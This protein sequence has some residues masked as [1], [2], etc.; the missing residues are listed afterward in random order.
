MPRFPYLSVIFLMLSAVMAAVIAPNAMRI[1]PP[2]ETIE[3]DLSARF[4]A[5]VRIDGAV[6]LR[7]VPRPQIIITQV[8]FSDKRRAAARFAATM[9]QMVADL[10]IIELVQRRFRV[11]EVTL[12]DA[13]VQL[14]LSE[15]PAS[16][17]AALR[18]G[19]LP[20]VNFLN[21][22]LRIIGLD[23]LRPQVVT[24]IENL[25]ASLMAQQ[26]NGPMVLV[27]QKVIADGHAAFLQ[28]TIGPPARE[29]QIGL[30]LGLGIDEQID[31]VGF[32]SGDAENWRLNGE[33]ELLSN[34]LLMTAIEARLP[35]Q[36]TTPGRRVQLTGLVSGSA[37]GIR[38]DSMEIEALNT[39]FRSRLALNW[40]R[41]AG[42]V[43]LLDGRMSTGAV[44]LDLLRFDNADKPSG[45]LND[46]WQG[47]APDLATSFDIEATR[48]VI[49]GETGSD[50]AAQVNQNGALL[51]VE[52][53]NMNLPFRSSLLAT[54]TLDTRQDKPVFT[55][56]FSTRSSDAL[57]LLLWLGNQNNIDFSAFAEA[58]DEGTLQRASLVGDVLLNQDGLA[59]KGLAG[60]LGDDYFSADISLPDING[61]QGD[62]L[63][64]I[65]N[66]DLADWG[67]VETA[68]AGRESGIVGV[69]PQ[70]DRLLARVLSTA[71]AARKIDFDIQIGRVFA[72]AQFIGPFKAKGTVADRQVQIDKLH[73]A[74]F[75]NAEVTLNGI[76]NYDA[77][78][79]HGALSL[80]IRGDDAKWA[81]GPIVSRFGPLDFNQ[82][83]AANMQFDIQL[84]APS[85]PDWPKVIYRGTGAFGATTAALSV[86]SPSR[87]LA[88]VEAGTE[89]ALSL[90][91][92]ANGLADLFFLPPVYGASDTATM[93][94]GLNAQ[95]NELLSVVANVALADDAMALNGTLRGAVGGKLLSGAL[96]FNFA[97]FLPLLDAD[98]S[99]ERIA[100]S[101]EM[102]LNATQNNFGFAGLNLTFGAGQISGEGVLQTG[103]NLPRLNA[104]LAAENADFSWMLPERDKS[105]W[106]NGP[107]RWSVLGRS[108]ADIQLTA[109]GSR[110]GD[111]ILDNL[112]GRLK[113][114][115]GV[116]EAPNLALELMG[117]TMTANLLAEGG[118]L[119]PRFGLDA[120]FT[121][122]NPNDFL[123]Q[124]YGNGLVNALL[125]GTLR[126]EGRGSSPRSMM[127]SLGG[128]VN[129]EIAP[130]QLTFFDAV[131]FVDKISAPNRQG[132]ATDLL[133]A[134]TGKKEL[135]FAR[136]LGLVQLR[137]GVV[138]TASTEFVFANGQN[139][140]RFSGALD[141]VDL[142]I[143]A[144]M[145]LYPIDRQRPI[146]WQ[147]TGGLAAPEI[148]ARA[149]AFDAPGSA[150]SATPPPAE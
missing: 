34:N 121:G 74:N 13:D 31:F 35:V 33:V 65:S 134:L 38:A 133:A 20:R 111:V 91:G 3:A 63:F 36:V 14:Q 100:A 106:R 9:P 96:E 40:P 139:E 109:A 37:S 64:G 72:G 21:S 53:L 102:Q 149:T 51:S 101:G 124:Q 145:R 95:G 46:I 138:E 56:N 93:E 1:L 126:L 120:S 104:N 17:I 83:V 130:G 43:P 88:F 84:T 76:L 30:V 25:S 41:M 71:D 67:I 141:M 148:K 112:S 94:L 24:R 147:L 113:L 136:G 6:R 99:W 105:G 39:V 2:I 16:L 23:P 57:A 114:T 108:N 123:A 132:A 75:A 7:F 62:V 73:L 116:L 11:D 86:T 146:I 59:L 18:G 19:S 80:A 32:L 47:V 48:F 69:L 128:E 110:F 137:N 78:P 49:G 117:G 66:F 44:N 140:A 125:S 8:S 135:T 70:L 127:A 81:H 22:G 144:E 98:T 131:G 143:D 129:Y 26:A 118:L 60:R 54:G 87:S 92:E 61:R 29:A 45:L 52:R 50:L 4:S 5:D 77:A 150:P 97:H 27:V 107:I 10:D 90:D 122:L 89:I 103:E 82:D 115:E 15:R 58:V 142:L 12:I 85:S 68:T 79:S 119:S 28:L 55:G 42:E